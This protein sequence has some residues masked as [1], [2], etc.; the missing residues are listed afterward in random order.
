MADYRPIATGSKRRYCDVTAEDTT[1]GPNAR[2]A[3]FHN[4]PTQNND[5]RLR[6]LTISLSKMNGSDGKVK[7]SR[8][9]LLI[10]NLMRSVVKTLKDDKIWD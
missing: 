5:N 4:T 3:P 6:I 10:R 2:M 9:T 1:E 8:K 7:F